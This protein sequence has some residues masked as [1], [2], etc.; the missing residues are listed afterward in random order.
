MAKKTQPPKPPSKV[1]LADDLRAGIRKL[2]RRIEDLSTFDVAI[3]V[4]RFDS[5]AQA[6]VSKIN[7]TLA[8]I[9]GRDT[10]EYRD[11]SIRSLDTLPFV[12]G[13]H[14]HPV[15][16]VRDAYQKGIDDS[17]TRLTSLRETLEEKLEDMENDIPGQIVTESNRKPPGKGEIFI[18]HG[19]DELAK[20]NVARFI[21]NLALKPI[22][23]HEQPSGGKTIIEKLEAHIYVDFAVVIL[24]PDDEGYPAGDEAKKKGRARQNV[25]LELGLFLGA[26]GRNRVCALH[27]GDVE[28]PSDYQGVI[29][30][31]MDDAGAWTMLL[32]R[33]IKKAGIN[34]D[35]N[36]II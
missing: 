31:P 2:D 18:V 13:G 12:V 34:V 6:L 3:I 1:L 35:M 16:V 5:K 28:I 14:K 4:E 17:I 19:H 26:L 25:I 11:H 10:P 8:D 32:A 22:I 23:L 9:F 33:E 36:K 15:N 7:I 21:S 24:T 27:K 20:Q 30:I 29:F